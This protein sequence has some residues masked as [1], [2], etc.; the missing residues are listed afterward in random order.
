MSILFVK[1][2]CLCPRK[3]KC[4]WEIIFRPSHIQ[5]FLL[6]EENRGNTYNNIM[7]LNFTPELSLSA[8]L[9]TLVCYLTEYMAVTLVQWCSLK[10]AGSL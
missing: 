7:K 3:I 8:L 1:Y 9:P 4:N 10:L 5:L 2:K 6:K